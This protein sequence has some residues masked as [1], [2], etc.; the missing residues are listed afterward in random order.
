M[1]LF[2]V[3]KKSEPAQPLRSPQSPIEAPMHS[4]SK[5]DVIGNKYEVHDVLG[6]GGCGIV[7]LVYCLESGSVYALKSFLDKF[8]ANLGV[9]D[10]F[11]KEALVWVNL[12]RHPFIVNAHFIDEISGRLFIATEYIAAGEN[13]F[14]SLETYLQNLQPTLEQ[15]LLW[16]I[17]FCHGME[18]S[19]SKGI[20]AHRD[21][22]PAN[23][24]IN[25]D[26]NVKISDFGL[27]GVIDTNMSLLQNVKI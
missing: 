23:I 22:K 19:Y 12:G 18:Y 13:G 15:S 20:K 3:F 16:A 11:K 5:G 6:K 26:G 24:L 25:V 27:A 9:R 8:I 10:R 7:Y 1:G 4:Y 14:N 2:D 17:Q 21:I